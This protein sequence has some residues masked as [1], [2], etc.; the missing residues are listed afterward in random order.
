MHVVQGSSD[1]EDAYQLGDAGS[2]EDEDKGEEDEAEVVHE[3]ANKKRQSAQKKR[4]TTTTVK[5]PSAKKQRLSN[6]TKTA[7]TDAPA[8]A[9]KA[10]KGYLASTCASTTKSR[11]TTK[12]VLFTLPSAPTDQP[13]SAPNADTTPGP[14][15]QDKGKG[16]MVYKREETAGPQ[17]NEPSTSTSSAVVLD[18]PGKA[19]APNQ[20]TRLTNTRGIAVAVQ[21]SGALKYKVYQA[22][23][24]KAIDAFIA[25]E[26]TE[27]ALAQQK[28]AKSLHKA[29]ELAKLSISTSKEGLTLPPR[30]FASPQFGNGQDTSVPGPLTATPTAPITLDQLGNHSALYCPE[31]HQ[32]IVQAT[33]HRDPSSASLVTPWNVAGPSVPTALEPSTKAPPAA[34]EENYTNIGVLTEGRHTVQPPPLVPRQGGKIHAQL[35]NAAGGNVEAQDQLWWEYMQFSEQDHKTI[36][37]H[38]KAKREILLYAWQ[39]IFTA[40][41]FYIKEKDL[42]ILEM[43]QKHATYFLTYRHTSL[44]YTG[45]KL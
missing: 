19:K 32:G 40:N 28:A 13:T 21:I 1:E 29:T 12:Q 42:W 16:K 36:N 22:L 33:V 26:H 27:V 9:S 17:P 24:K 23:K 43:V 34:E 30:Y 5:T 25:A 15:W 14:S 20:S 10:P 45:V 18:K 3:C 44:I 4:K 38:V 35:R 6:S 37:P 7:A 11:S 31:S 2:S 8:N 41:P 39:P